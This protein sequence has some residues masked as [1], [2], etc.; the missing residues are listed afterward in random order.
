[1]SLVSDNGPLHHVQKPC[2]S[3]RWRSAALSS[4]GRWFDTFAKTDHVCNRHS[5]VRMRM[6]IHDPISPC[7]A[8]VRDLMPD[9][10]MRNMSASSQHVESV[11]GGTHV[12]ARCFTI[13]SA[14]ASKSGHSAQEHI[15][16][17]A[18]DSLSST[19]DCILTMSSASACRHSGGLVCCVSC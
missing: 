19:A 12:V 15:E 9:A 3:I 13:A 7:L 1:M 10:T 16:P 14:L 18:R 8:E 5:L 11:N 2:N 6:E 17:P 4:G